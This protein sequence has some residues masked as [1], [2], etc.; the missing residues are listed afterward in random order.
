MSFD[1]VQEGEGGA[2]RIDRMT[3]GTS[4]LMKEATRRP[5]RMLPPWT[6]PRGMPWASQGPG[7]ER[8]GVRRRE[9]RDRAGAA[10][11]G[12]ATDTAAGGRRSAGVR[13]GRAAALA[14][15]E[16]VGS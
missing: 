10:T 9:R 12:V 15:A 11:G 1:V 14:A 13:R 7:G 3:A 4:L 16:E 8:R 6:C 5:W 2:R